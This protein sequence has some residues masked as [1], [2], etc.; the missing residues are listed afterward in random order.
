MDLFFFEPSSEIGPSVSFDLQQGDPELI[1]DF[2]SPPMSESKE[3][4]LSWLI[5]CLLL[6]STGEIFCYFPFP[7]SLQNIEPVL[8]L[9]PPFPSWDLLSFASPKHIGGLF[10]E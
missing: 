5:V 2:P 9:V 4:A 6:L 1:P 7:F 10:P 3:S 8:P